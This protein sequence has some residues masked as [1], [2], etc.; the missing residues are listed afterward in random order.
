MASLA[1]YDIALLDTDYPTKYSGLLVAVAGYLTELE[2]ARQG[3][4]SLLVN[5]QRYIVA[6]TGLAANLPA[7]GF[8]IT[9]LGTPTATTDAATKSYADGLSF[10]AALPAQA[11]S[12]GLE[13]TT[14]GTT[15]SWGVTAFGALATLNFLGA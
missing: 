4:A 14:D 1:A 8:K 2:N 13:I 12:A 5:L 3:Q 10:A 9:N 7:G 11:G 15:A 6:N